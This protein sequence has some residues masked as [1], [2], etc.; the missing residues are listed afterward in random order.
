M[1]KKNNIVDSY[2]CKSKG[3]AKLKDCVCA[4]C[5]MAA[6][7][8]TLKKSGTAYFVLCENIVAANLN[9]NDSP[10]KQS[11]LL[12]TIVVGTKKVD[13]NRISVTI[14][15]YE[16]KYYKLTGKTWVCPATSLYPA[17]SEMIPYIIPVPS[18]SRVN[19]LQNKDLCLNLRGLEPGNEVYVVQS[20][21]DNPCRAV[22]KDV[23]PRP[24]LGEGIYFDVELLV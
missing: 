14:S 2:V 1:T 13:S 6:K 18:Q 22:I 19:L 21:E 23:G 7:K 8:K 16:K 5:E 15:E 20:H 17:P 10:H 3:Y 12:G 4:N 24:K 11:L 9:P